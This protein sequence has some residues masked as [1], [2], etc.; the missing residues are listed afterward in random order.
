MNINQ[1]RDTDKNT[2]P[3]SKQIIQLFKDNDFIIDIETNLEELN[4]LDITFNLTNGSY[5]SYKNSNDELK[6]INVLSTHPSQILKQLTT[7]ISDR[8]SRNSSSELIFN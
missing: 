7:I 3:I 5:R 2:D 6:Y 4:F 1:W 8:L